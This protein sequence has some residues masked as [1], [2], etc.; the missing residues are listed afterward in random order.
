MVAS[1]TPWAVVL[2]VA[3]LS[4]SA[5]GLSATAS[6]SYSDDASEESVDASSSAGES[7]ATGGVV[8]PFVRRV[9]RRSV[10]DVFG[11]VGVVV[12]DHPSPGV[13]DAV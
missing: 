9:E 10:W 7:G 3:F 4:E 8:F 2:S 1:A 13:A 12:L 5:T 6:S 11:G